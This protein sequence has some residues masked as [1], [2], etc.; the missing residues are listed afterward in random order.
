ERIDDAEQALVPCTGAAVQLAAEADA[1]GR[2]AALIERLREAVESG[3]V[4]A[5]A[6]A[7]AAHLEAGGLVPADLAQQVD[8]VERIGGRGWER[9]ARGR[10]RERAEQGRAAEPVGRARAVVRHR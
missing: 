9:R 7:G 6:A 2:I 8:A 1:G 5:E 4:G 3:L 10:A